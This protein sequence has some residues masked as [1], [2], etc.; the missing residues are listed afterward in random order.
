LE[1]A[2]TLY[3]YDCDPARAGEAKCRVSRTDPTVAQPSAV[4][5]F[6]AR[7]ERDLAVASEDVGAYTLTLQNRLGAGMVEYP[8]AL[9]YGGALSKQHYLTR[10]ANGDGSHSHFVLPLQWNVAGD[11][12][13]PSSDD[14]V[15]R[16][17]RSELWYD[18]AG[19]ELRE[20]P[21]EEAFDA[22]CAG[23]HLTGMRLSGSA[24]AGLHAHAAG[25]VSGELDFDG[26]GRREELNVGCE[27]CHGPG[28]EHLEAKTRGLAIVSPSLLTPEREALLCGRCH[29]RPL[30]KAAVATRA[31]LGPD[32]TMPPPWLRRAEY[33]TGYVTRVDGDAADFH[34]SGDSKAHYAQYSDFVRSAMYRNGAVLMTCTSCHDAHGSE[35]HAHDLLRAADDDTACTGCHS[36]AQYTAPRGHVEQATG[37]VHDGSSE[38]DFTCTSCHMVKTATSGARHPE[39]LDRIPDAPRVQYFHG[40]VASHRFTVPP[41]VRYREQPVAATLA[42]GFCHGEQLENP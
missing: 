17:Y 26:D 42:C 1:T 29:S 38:S 9:S 12:T 3:F 31:P 5:S 18:F 13:H 33:V 10:L 24:T 22:Q 8:L 41:R 23:C 30:G 35:Q 4:V 28:S 40:D 25:D 16:D 11:D 20:P 32:G 14:W 6:E 15:F 34:P 36:Q 27:S 39:L 19:S 37:F 21:N 7:L 2:A